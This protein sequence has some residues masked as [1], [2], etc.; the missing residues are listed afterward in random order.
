MAAVQLDAR[1]LDDHATAPAAVNASTCSRTSWTRKMDAPRSY[2]AT[3]APSEAASVP[4]V[5]VL[6]GGRWRHVV[7]LMDFGPVAW[8]RVAAVYVIAVAPG[9]TPAVGIAAFGIFGVGLGMINTLIFAVQA[10][11]VDY[12]EWKSGIRAE[13]SS[14]AV[15]SFMRKAGQGVGGGLAAYTIGLGGYISGAAT[16]T[17]EAVTAIRLAFGVVPAVAALAAGAVMLTYPLTEKAFRAIVAEMAQRRVAETVATLD[18]ADP[19][20][21]DPGDGPGTTADRPAGR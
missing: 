4:V 20:D 6:D 16:Q 17:S 3:A 10:D 5:E 8:R 9:S 11:T 7:R 18:T 13:G 21:P 15:L 19:V 2:A 12:G 14:Y 1:Q